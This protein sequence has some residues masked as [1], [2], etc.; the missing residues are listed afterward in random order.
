MRVTSNKFVDNL[1]QKKLV[2]PPYWC[3]LVFGQEGA[4]SPPTPMSAM[5]II[6]NMPEQ[7]LFSTIG[8]AALQLPIISLGLIM[9]GH[10]RVGFEDN[11]YYRRGEKAKS[12][13]Q[14]VERAVRLVHEL[15]REVATPSQAREMLNISQNPTQYP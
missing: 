8:I 1:I 4:C 9:G 11:V 7:S 10:I 15:N 14:F 12:N 3:Q 13:Q 2:D 5:E 6:A